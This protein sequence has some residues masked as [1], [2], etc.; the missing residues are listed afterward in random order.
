MDF[1][2]FMLDTYDSY[3]NSELDN[4]IKNGNTVGKGR[5]RHDRIP[6][7]EGVGKNRSI[8]IRRTAGHETL[9]R[10]VGRWFPRNDEPVSRELYCAS[11]LLLLSPWRNLRDLKGPME[12]FSDSFGRFST[13]NSNNSKIQRILDNI[14]YYHDCKDAAR[15][16]PDENN[17][18][19]FV[20]I[21]IEEEIRAELEALG[22]DDDTTRSAREYTEEDIKTVRNAREADRERLYGE[23]AML[24]AKE[25]GIFEEETN[26]ASNQ[27]LEDVAT[28]ADSTMLNNL[29]IWN[30]HLTSVTRQQAKEDGIVN[31]ATIKQPRIVPNEERGTQTKSIITQPKIF[32]VSDQQKSSSRPLLATLNGE[33]KRAHDIIE[34]VLIKEL[35]GSN[36]QL[37]HEILIHSH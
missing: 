28:H 6:Y 22:I 3:Y 15:K 34:G 31:L 20:D 16:K 11:M 13:H 7:L 17:N 26:E 35:S 32:S 2:S 36:G 10:F 29:H 8:R 1:L 25:A 21:D 27:P 24:I 23:R 30:D 12:T 4:N 5:P 9:P 37:R 19:Q 18:C 14:Q 33:Q